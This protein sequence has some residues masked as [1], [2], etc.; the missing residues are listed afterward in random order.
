[1]ARSYRQSETLYGEAS[2]VLAGGVSSNFRYIGY[3][4]SPVPVFYERGEGARLYDVDGNTVIDYAAANGATVLGHAPPVVTEAVA[5]SLKLGQLFAGQH[6]ME[7]DLARRICDLV[8]CAEL[9]RFASSGSEADQAVIRLA[10][11]ATGRTKVVKFEGHYHGWFDN[12]LISIN[13]PVDKAG[14]ANAPFSFGH[15]PGQAP[16]AL[17]DVIVLPWNDLDLFRCTLEDQGHEIAG[18]IMEPIPCNT[19]AIMPVEGYLEGV[20]QLTAKHGIVLIFDE[21][22]T[23]F[24]VAIGGAQS[25]LRVT[26]DLAVFAKALGAGFPLAALAGKRS[27]ME[28]VKTAGVMHGGTYNANLPVLAAGLATLR[29]LT[30]GNGEVLASIGEKTEHLI[31]GLRKLATKHGQNMH[32]CGLAGVFHPAFGDGRE[33]RTYRDFLSTDAEKRTHFNALLHEEGVRV[34]ARG[35]WFVTAALTDRDIEETL[36]AADRALE[37]LVS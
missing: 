16:S 26:P 37:K 19:G 3:G 28:L 8:P 5:Q 2:Q 25:Y 33:I 22:I 12:V 1:M 7:A 9:V 20:R 18:V 32:V 14:P 15:T 35:T 36:Q 23:G 13:P 29:E 17:S 21:V 30:R 4:K 31:G 34:T 24:R 6:R 11:A 10:R 27:I